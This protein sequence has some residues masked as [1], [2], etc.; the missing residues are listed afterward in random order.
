MKFVSFSLL[1]LKQG[2]KKRFLYSLSQTTSLLLQHQYVSFAGTETV[3]AKQ[4]VNKEAIQFATCTSPIMH[5]ICP[6]KFCISIVFNFSCDGYNTQEKWKTKVMQNSRGQIRCIMGD[7][8]V[9]N[10]RIGI[11]TAGRRIKSKNDQHSYGRNFAVAK[12]NLKKFW[13]VRDLNTTN[14]EKLN[15]SVYNNQTTIS[16]DKNW[17]WRRWEKK[18]KTKEILGHSSDKYITEVFKSI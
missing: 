12:Q 4:F 3:V 14:D 17:T 18:N 1:P 7:V 2:K 16:R 11:W 13:F 6:L 8:Q 15:S 5:L 10:I 9:A